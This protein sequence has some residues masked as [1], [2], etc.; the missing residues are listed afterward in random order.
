MSEAS[1]SAPRHV[2]VMP[3]EVLHWLAPAQV[4]VDATAGAGGHSLLLAPRL[5]SGGRVI[6]LDRD[7]A[8]L[9]LARARLQGLPVSLVQASFD[10][11]RQVLDDLGIQAVDG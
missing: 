4:I 3:A 8:M 9:D 2:S 10:Q 6:A 1:S 7:P 5:A 11:L